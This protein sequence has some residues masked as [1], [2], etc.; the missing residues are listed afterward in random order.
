M[1]QIKSAYWQNVVER[2]QQHPAVAG[3]TQI[4]FFSMAPMEG[5]TDSV[6]RR[7]VAQ[8]GG[9]DVYFTEFTNARSIT[10]PKAKFTAQVRLNVAPG[11]QMPIAQIWGNRQIDF[12]TASQDLKAHG[13]QAIDLNMGCPSA[14][15]IKNGG[16]SDLIRHLD[17]AAAVIA[18]AKTA[19]L[20]VSVKT[21]LGFNEL[22][23]Y[24]TWIPF[25][26]KQDIPLLTVHV[27]SRKEMSKVPAH[28]ELIDELVALRDQYA[29]NTLL[30]INGDIKDRAAGL[31]L[32]RQHPGVDGIMIGRGIFENPFAF[33]DTPKEHTLAENLHLLRMQLDLH[34]QFNA[35]HGPLNFR[36][37]RR[38][39]KIYV[40][41]FDNASDLRVAL[42]DSNSTDEARQLLD[43]FEQQM[44]AP[45]Q[46]VIPIKKSSR[47][48]NTDDQ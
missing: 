23:T 44:V 40:R 20:P 36:K 35:E 28:Y 19:G 42:M 14:T 18:G 1:V 26:L 24:K 29:P 47:Q 38:F 46:I 6:F 45:E 2:A 21:R 41:H 4:P 17:D 8:A 31:A 10:H 27:R 22:D 33:E 30:Q 13:Y 7:V 12:E 3:L 16:G 39:F 5:V 9:P 37:L 25:L 43:D 48:S 34:D 11:E 32:V 15:I